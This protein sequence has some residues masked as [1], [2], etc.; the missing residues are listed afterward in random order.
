LTE[1]RKVARVGLSITKTTTIALVALGT[2][3]A[4]AIRRAV[5]SEECAATSA[6][7]LLGLKETEIE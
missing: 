2:T 5:S 7:A 6:F 3:K 4:V 1:T